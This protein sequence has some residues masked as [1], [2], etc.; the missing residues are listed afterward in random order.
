MLGFLELFNCV[1]IIPIL[2]G[3]KLSLTHLKIE[4][5]TLDL[6]LVCLTI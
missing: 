5:E 6:Q 3:K 2:V 1:Q 4:L